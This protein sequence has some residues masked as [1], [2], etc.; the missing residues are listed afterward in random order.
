MY[1]TALSP[2]RPI[3]VV[4]RLFAVVTRPNTA[5]ARPNRLSVSPQPV[6]LDGQHGRL[7][8]GSARMTKRY[9]GFELETMI[10]KYGSEALQYHLVSGTG[11]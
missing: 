9:D 5:L 8:H 2:L 1:D 11:R 3:S 7:T 4:R 10:A 6:H